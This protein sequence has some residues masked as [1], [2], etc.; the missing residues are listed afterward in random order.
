[1]PKIANALPISSIHTSDD[2]LR[3]LMRLQ[4]RL[5]RGFETARSVVSVWPRFDTTDQMKR[6]VR[7]FTSFRFACASSDEQRDYVKGALQTLAEARGRLPPTGPGIVY[8][9]IPSHHEVPVDERLEQIG[10]G[11]KSQLRT[12]NTRIIWRCSVKLNRSRETI[13]TFLPCRRASAQTSE[14]RRK[15]AGATQ[16]TLSSE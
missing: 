12:E 10:E 3:G 5:R 4:T 11:L 15:P 7:R 13:T 6:S 8:M 16:I 9:D 1:M 2:L 14:E